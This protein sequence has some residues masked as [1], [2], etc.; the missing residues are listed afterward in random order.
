MLNKEAFELVD[1]RA[2]YAVRRVPALGAAAPAQLGTGSYMGCA[3][4]PDGTTFYYGSANEGR[5]LLLARRGIAFRGNRVQECGC[6]AGSS[7][8]IVARAE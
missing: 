4:S 6:V 5:S 7:A 1:L 8:A 2:P 3:F